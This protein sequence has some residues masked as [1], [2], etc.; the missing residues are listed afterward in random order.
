MAESEA[1]LTLMRQGWGKEKSPFRQMF[2]SLY[3]PD[4]TDE[5]I[6]WWT[7]LQRVATSPEN[8]V[9]LRRVIDDLDVSDK[10]TKLRT[11]TLILHSEREMVAP[12]AEA[13]FMAARIPDARFRP[14]DS[15]NHLV[16]QQEPAWQRAVSE[17]RDFLAD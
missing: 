9:R 6:R 5:Q 11:P 17:I 7:D 10:L 8:A 16:M 13:R 3:L 1:L 12:L 14:L 15:G 2:A 4:A